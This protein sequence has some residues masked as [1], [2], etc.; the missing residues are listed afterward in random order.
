MAEKNISKPYDKLA[1][2]YNRIMRK[3]NYEKW[4]EYIWTIAVANI[5]GEISA[6]ELGSGTCRFANILKR[7]V[8]SII[9]SDISSSML[10]QST[11]K[12]LKKVC[13]NMTA[14]PLKKKFNLVISLFD[15]VNYLTSKKKFFNMLKN[16]ESILADDGIFTFDVSLEKNSYK[17]IKYSNHSGKIKN[18]RYEHQTNYNAETRIHKNIFIIIF[19]DD[20]QVIEVHKQKIYPFNFYFEVIEKTNLYV[21]DCFRAFTF[22]KGNANSDRLQFILKKRKQ[23]AL[24]Y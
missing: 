13:F 12:K 1:I 18:I 7:N 6:L 11:D 4:A 14:I 8:K 19:K 2:V 3:V 22:T 23:D 16:V 24:S 21:A 17:F 15:S 9:A 20:Q 10:L 5:D